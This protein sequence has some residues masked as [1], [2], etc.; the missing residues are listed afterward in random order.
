MTLA[1]VSVLALAGT[2]YLFIALRAAARRHDPR[3]DWSR[4]L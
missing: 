2:T 4:I 1:L 3:D